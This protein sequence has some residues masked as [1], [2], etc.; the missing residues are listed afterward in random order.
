MRNLTSQLRSLIRR[1]PAYSARGFLSAFKPTTIVP[2][3]DTPNHPKAEKASADPPRKIDS[4]V[5]PINTPAEHPSVTSSEQGF[6]GIDGEFFEAL[7]GV[8][9]ESG[10]AVSDDIRLHDAIT[11]MAAAGSKPMMIRGI[12]FDTKGN[13]KKL[14]ESFHRAHFCSYNSLQPRDLRKLDSTLMTEQQSSSQVV[15]VREKAIL[16]NLAHVQALIRADN[17]MLV[18]PPT[19]D[20]KH[21]ELQSSFIYELQGRLQTNR[22]SSIFELKVM[23]TI[24][25]SVTAGFKTEMK[26]LE[27]DAVKLL[28][29]VDAGVDGERLKSLLLLR[30]AY[31]KFIPKVDGFR[32]AVSDLLNND[33]DLAGMYLTDKSN[34]KPREISDHMDM[35]LLL[36]HYIKIGDEIKARLLETTTNLQTTQ[37]MIGIILD[38]QRNE[39]IIFDLQANLAT[40]A[41]SSAALVAALLGMNV[42]NHIEDLPFAFA[43]ICLGSIGVAGGVY[44]GAIYKMSRIIKWKGLVDHLRMKG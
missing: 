13:V 7:D 15:L 35:E 21:G 20:L 19:D 27:R 41:I 25:A 31:N 40:A 14:D 30:R 22:D 17:V 4:K 23:E 2:P 18:S 6:L 11:A 33:E 10:L 36:E 43:S 26:Q 28:A 44:F 42:P 37:N 24:L 29:S 34:G 16:V 1:T 32:E 5:H 12:I 8:K 39:L 9:V 3:K 38:S